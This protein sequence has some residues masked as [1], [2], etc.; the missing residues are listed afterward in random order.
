MANLALSVLTEHDVRLLHCLQSSLHERHV[1]NVLIKHFGQHAKFGSVGP[2]VVNTK[3]MNW[4]GDRLFFS[5]RARREEH[6]FM[7]TH[8]GIIAIRAEAIDDLVKRSPRMKVGEQ[9]EVDRISEFGVAYLFDSIAD[10]RA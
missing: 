10:E 5:R 4:C 9:C 1:V 3:P 6:A 2:I 8:I 7:N